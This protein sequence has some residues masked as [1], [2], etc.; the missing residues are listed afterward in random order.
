[1]PSGIAPLIRRSR[2]LW[3]TSQKRFRMAGKSDNTWR[4]RMWVMA[5]T[6]IVMSASAGCALDGNA[7]D[8]FTQ[9]HT[10]PTD[11]VTVTKLP[12]QAPPAD[13]ASDPQRLDLWHSQH[14]D[15]QRF[16]VEGCGY[17][18]DLDCWHGEHLVH[19]G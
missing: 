8:A 17:A 16:H 9:L 4:G 15:H 3:G 11:R 2:V 5:A 19:C 1:L 7:R 10:C 18:N 14:D 12:P 13:V 6:S